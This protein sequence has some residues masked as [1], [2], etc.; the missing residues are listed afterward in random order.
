MGGKKKYWAIC[1]TAHMP[2]KGQMTQGKNT[3]GLI[4]WC[5]EQAA[6]W[7]LLEPEHGSAQTRS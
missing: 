6:F 3:Q 7:A 1:C 4:L 2:D 5:P